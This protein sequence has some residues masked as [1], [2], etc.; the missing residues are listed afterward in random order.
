L[1]TQQMLRVIGTVE[2]TDIYVVVSLLLVIVVLSPLLWHQPTMGPA[3]GDQL[4]TRFLLSY[5]SL[6]LWNKLDF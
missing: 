4:L 3:S 6:V 1:C 2:L 5:V